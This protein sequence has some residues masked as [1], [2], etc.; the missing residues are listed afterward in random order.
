M[1]ET[2]KRA[3]TGTS[4]VTDSL[5]PRMFITVKRA[6]PAKETGSLS[7]CADSGMKLKTASAPL[8]IEIV[9]VKM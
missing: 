6:T 4:A 7:Q 9:I 2:T 1:C 5:T 3:N 8:A